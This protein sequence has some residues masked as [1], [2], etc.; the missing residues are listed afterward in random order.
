VALLFAEKCGVALVV[1]HLVRGVTT[2]PK[3]QSSGKHIQGRLMVL[4]QLV[5]THGIGNDK[6]AYNPV[7][8]MALK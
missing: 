8:D 4:H 7:V 3:L 6:V 5:Q 1:G 2:K